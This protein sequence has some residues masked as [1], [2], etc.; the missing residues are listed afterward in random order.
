MRRILALISFFLVFAVVEAQD[1]HFSQYYW[2]YMNLNPALTGQFS[3]NYRLN[4][5]FKN[6]WSSISEPFTTLSF[7][8]EGKRLIKS[9]APLNIGLSILSDQAGLGDLQTNQFNLSVARNWKLNADSSLSVGTGLQ[10]GFTIRSI[11]FNNF[12]FDQQYNGSRFVEGRANGENFGPSSFGFANVNLGIALHYKLENRKEYSLGFSSYNLSRPNQSFLNSNI[13]LDVRNQFYLTAQHDISDKLDLE[14]SLYF[15]TQGPNRE[16]FIGT[17]VK[18][19]FGESSSINRNLFLGL[20]Y[21]HQDAL[22]PLIGLEYDAWRVGVNYDINISDL[23]VATNGRGGIEFS[24]TYI[25]STYKPKNIK[26]KRCPK[27]I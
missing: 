24:L 11:N 6:Q 3:G 2:S 26:F 10:F 18:Y 21:R 16:L 9:Y 1:T 22:V 27:F 14:P 25:I 13:P 8:A 5:N 20:W 17:N 19:Y 4:S 12:T 7:S 23:T 15:S